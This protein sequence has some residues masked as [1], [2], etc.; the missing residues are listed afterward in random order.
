MATVTHKTEQL[1]LILS[2]NHRETIQF[3]VFSSPS[4]PLILGYPWL[5][6]N[7]PNIDWAQLRILNWSTTNIMYI[8][9]PKLFLCLHIGLMMCNRSPS[10]LNLFIQS[11]VSSVQTRDPSNGNLYQNFTG[12]GYYQTILLAFGCCFLFVGKKNLSLL[13]LVTL[14]QKDLR[15]LPSPSTVWTIHQCCLSCLIFPQQP[16]C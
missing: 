12:S 7:Y 11:S 15:T 13:F 10:W 1:S 16:S 8:T 4:T 9:K 14:S 5:C 2:G 3:H 6:K